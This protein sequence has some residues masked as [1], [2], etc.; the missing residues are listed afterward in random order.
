MKMGMKPLVALDPLSWV[1]SWLLIQRARNK[2]ELKVSTHKVHMNA[3]CAANFILSLAVRLMLKECAR[4]CAVKCSMA[5]YS[6]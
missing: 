5:L 4:S 1:A 3:A 2:Q 6:S